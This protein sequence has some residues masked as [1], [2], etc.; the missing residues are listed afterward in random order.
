M[1]VELTPWLAAPVDPVVSAQEL[2]LWRFSLKRMPHSLQ[3]YSDILSS[4]EVR[5]AEKLISPQKKSDFIVARAQLR[6]ILAAYLRCFPA[7]IE[8]TYN[9]QGKPFL[10][11]SAEQQLSFNLSHAGGRGLLA[12]MKTTPVGVDIERID[13][14]IDCLA[15]ARRYFSSAEERFLQRLPAEKQAIHFFRVWTRKEALLKMLGIGLGSVGEIPSSQ[16]TPRFLRHIPIGAG[17]IAAVA[18]RDA[19]TTVV[20]YKL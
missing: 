1:G 12:L 9:P 10:L 19:V 16:E 14:N 4:D 5:R 2:H 3:Q 6:L 15:I 13:R 17:Y 8:F 11:H 7:R 20:R 18:A